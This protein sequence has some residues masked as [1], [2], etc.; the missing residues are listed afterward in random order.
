MIKRIYFRDLISVIP[1]GEV[2]YFYIPVDDPVNTW[3]K[4]GWYKLNDF[5]L[6]QECSALLDYVVDEIANG[7]GCINVNL[8]RKEV[9]VNG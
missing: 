8:M 5:L 7:N 4:K 9:A 6:S 1:A 3:I 2:V